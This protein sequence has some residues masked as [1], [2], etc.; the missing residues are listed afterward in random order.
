MDGRSN[1]AMKTKNPKIKFWELIKSRR[2]TRVFRTEIVPSELI[3]NIIQAGCCSPSAHNGQPWR[4]M[5]FTGRSER[6]RFA[7]LM[8]KH[9][10]HELTQN[11]ESVESIE[12]R[13]ERTILR[14]TNAP[15]AILICCEYPQ[16]DG[17]PANITMERML[18][19]QSVA[20]A[21]GYML[22]AAQAEGLGAC[23]VGYPTFC[24]SSL[25]EEFGLPVNWEPQ[26]AILVGYP[27]EIPLE[28]TRTPIDRM[29]LS[30]RGIADGS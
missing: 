14:L 5:T 15:V 29:V 18:H 19:I 28:A 8:T 11:G 1:H 13:K 7:E 10:Q 27:G 26:A 12:K 16:M 3:R 24:P 2:S 22:L 4:F 17:K 25:F 30:A 9:M 23:W 21:I 20:S 6:V